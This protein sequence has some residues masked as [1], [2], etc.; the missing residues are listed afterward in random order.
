MLILMENHGY[1]DIIGDTTDAPYI[2]S[3]ATGYAS[4]TAWSDVSHPSLPNY[5]AL[6]AG[7]IFSDP[8][9]C[10]PT[11]AASVD[12]N[13]TFDMS[14]TSLA[15]QLSTAGIPWKA[16]MEDM[17]TACDST[18]T[19]SPGNYDVNHNPFVYYDEV[20]HTAATCNQIVPYSELMTDL[21]SGSLPAFM[22][23]TPNLIHDMHDGTIADGDN[24]LKGLI[25]SIMGSDWYKHGGSII[26]TWDED[27]S[28]TEQ[29][30]L[31]VVSQANMGR[32]AF[33]PAGNH[34]G[35]LRGIEEV[36]G[37]SLLQS[38]AD[39]ASGDVRPLL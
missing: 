36:Y 35:T 25:Q 22:W 7:S 38:A 1:S 37:L 6:T 17:P 21:T 26:I 3:L 39:A 30:A 4:A 13:C 14:T 29:I 20:V 16:Y 32:G 2:N 15:D 28:G 34:Y 23:V 24:F 18:D 27:E 12:G 10:V 8:A 19:F 33:G 5:L 11:W 31:I 9:D